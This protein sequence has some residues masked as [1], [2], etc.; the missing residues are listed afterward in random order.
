MSKPRW[1]LLL[2]C[3]CVI[4]MSLIAQQGDQMGEIERQII[5]KFLKAKPVPAAPHASAKRELIEELHGYAAKKPDLK[6]PD[7][8]AKYVS[9][10]ETLLGNLKALSADDRKTLK[11]VKNVE[12]YLKRLKAKSSKTYLTAIVKSVAKIEIPKSAGNADYRRQIEQLLAMPSDEAHDGLLDEK[13][14]VSATK[15]Q[16][17]HPIHF[18][19]W[20]LSQ[21]AYA[22]ISPVY[23]SMQN[24][25]NKLTSG[26]NGDFCIRCHNQVGMNKKEST[27]A[28]NLERHPAS[29]EGIT[30]VVCHR[31]SPGKQTAKGSL[32]YGKVSG[33]IGLLKAD[34]SGIVFGPRPDDSVKEAIDT[35]KGQA[36]HVDSKKFAQINTSGFCGTC[37]DVNLF[38]GFRLE[39]AFS[40]YKNSA[41]AKKGISCQDCHMGVEQGFAL[42]DAGGSL[43]A[44]NYHVGLAATASTAKRKITNHMFSGPDHTVVHPG[45]FPVDDLLVKMATMQE[46]LDFDFESGWGSKLWED[47]FSAAADPEAVKQFAP[48]AATGQPFRW[49]YA[50]D[51]KKAREVIYLQMNKLAEARR[52][53]LVVLRNG[54]LLAETETGDTQN[55]TKIRVSA[56]SQGDGI[57]FDI[58]VKN[59]TDGHSVP[60]GFIAERLVWLQVDV[61]KVGADR[62]LFQ[63]G[64][65]DPNGDLR[66]S[67]ST[68]VHN[69]DSRWAIADGIGAQRLLVSPSKTIDNDEHIRV[70]VDRQLFNLQS[71]FITRNIRGGEREQV[72]AVNHSVDLLPFIRPS[73]RSTVLTGQPAGARI[74]RK[75]IPPNVVRKASYKV[76]RDLL[77]GSGDYVIEVK[78]VAGMIPVNLL[79][80]IE[81]VGFDYGM[82]TRGLARRVVFGYKTEIDAMRYHS[83]KSAAD[84]KAV[85]ANAGYRQRAEKE[86]AP[87]LRVLNAPDAA[88]WIDLACVNYYARDV[89][90][91]KIDFAM[92]RI[93]ALPDYSTIAAQYLYKRSLESLKLDNIDQSDELVSFLVRW[94]RQAGADIEKIDEILAI[95][96]TDKY[97]NDYWSS[98]EIYEKN[99]GLLLSKIAGHEV[100]ESQKRTVRVD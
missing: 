84:V 11:A 87:Q 55:S 88:Y 66:D 28:S 63:S 37:H 65:L 36:V 20:S 71:N 86:L 92:E 12:K 8:V 82:S 19:Q 75:N 31:I 43:S 39:E 69:G 83:F 70:A 94:K 64:D 42:T 61:T 54:Y 72:L 2:F 47:S 9:D 1:L 30:C 97:E 45:I 14:Y 60:T 33:R 77:D 73:T 100:L 93:V 91:K 98:S 74:H 95:I 4:P 76:H 40:E 21:H 32:P 56:A 89:Q 22:Q 52:H 50:E 13:E 78:L 24:Q 23:L 27:Y 44:R 58:G 90:Q 57:R 62:P 5:E 29:R 3:T 59:G 80:A 26:T 18:K 96:L 6:K 68:F 99:H 15:C 46:W 81:S 7:A 85:T 48:A 41:A 67:H 34:L 17:C 35:I 49:M 25:I 51:R 10:V 53:R 16:T 79:S 38:N